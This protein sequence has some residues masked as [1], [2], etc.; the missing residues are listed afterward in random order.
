VGRRH[1]ITGPEIPISGPPTN[2]IVEL[3]LLFSTNL[4]LGDDI[5][6]NLLT[7]IICAIG[8]GWILILIL[9]LLGMA[10]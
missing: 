4:F 2:S 10:Y 1:P 9:Q 8:E 7:L 5:P 3:V 6:I